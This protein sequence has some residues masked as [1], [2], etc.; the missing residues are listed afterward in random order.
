MVNFHDPAVIAADTFR[1][2]Q[3][4]NVVFGLFIWEFV[5]NLDYEWSVIRGH[6]PYRW[7]IWIYSLTRVLTLMDVA[8]NFYTVDGDISISCQA[9]STAQLAFAFLTLACASLLI[10]LRVIAIW[11]RKRVVMA[12]AGGLW[13]TNVIFLIQGV[14]RLRA[15]WVPE[16]NS[17]MMVQVEC[18]QLSTVVALV[19][20]VGLLLIMLFGVFRL[21][22]NGGGTMPL[23]RLLWNQGIIWLSLTTVAETLPTVFIYLN[24][25]EPLNMI[26]QIPW[27]ITMSVTATRMYRS[28]SDF[29]FSDTRIKGTPVTSIPLTGVQIAVHTT[30]E[31]YPTPR[32]NS[33][34]STDSEM[35]GKIVIGSDDIIEVRTGK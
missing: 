32:T 12:I 23:G 27:V 31:E 30:H 6:R 13:T 29:G 18:I 19:T 16:Q 14:A 21:R 7:T 11:N 3:F 1:A 20:D 35:Q 10:V 15:K 25:N 26:F 24:L 17:C 22:Q 5:T 33:Y 9:S 2:L 34:I 28:L 4:W 8:L